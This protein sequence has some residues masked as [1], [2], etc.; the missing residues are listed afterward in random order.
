MGTSGR[1]SAPYAFD[2]ARSPLRASRNRSEETRRVD[3]I[4]VKTKLVE[5]F[6]ESFQTL[7]A[8]NDSYVNRARI[9]V[10]GPR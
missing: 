8:L 4:D 1:L 10:Q 9:A 2:R 6:V 3:R 7:P 5:T